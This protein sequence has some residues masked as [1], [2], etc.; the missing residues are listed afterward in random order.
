MAKL[1]DDPAVQA[2]I[3]KAVTAAAKEREK[4]LK[5]KTKVAA[6][7]VKDITSRHVDEADDKAVRRALKE[8]GNDLLAAVKEA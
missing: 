5:A 7:L 8:L 1:K 3:A 2:L 4:A 6:V